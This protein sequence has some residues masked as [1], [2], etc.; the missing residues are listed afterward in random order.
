MRNISL[1]LFIIC[2]AALPGCCGDE[3]LF[4]LFD[5][6]CNPPPAAPPPCDQ[7]M[8]SP[9]WG[10]CGQPPESVQ[11][12]EVW[13][14]VPVQTF[15]GPSQRIMTSPPREER[16]EIPAV[17]EEVTEERVVEPARTEW[18][19]VDCPNEGES[20]CW[21]LVEIPAV[22]EQVTYQRVVQPATYRIERIPAAYEDVQ[23]APGMTYEWR[24]STEC[25]PGEAVS[26]FSSVS[27]DLPPAR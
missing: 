9:N 11:P 13:C 12:G 26:T 14:C 24:R 25:E 5:D 4:G 23:Q 1:F 27:D 19:S 7:P 3:A 20:E 16:V 2:A 17:F 21:M 22:T 10:P 18:R 6:G 8:A 15:S